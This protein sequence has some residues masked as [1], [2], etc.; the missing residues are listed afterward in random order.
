MNAKTTL[1]CF[2]VSNE[3]I[4][5]AILTVGTTVKS[6]LQPS[7]YGAERLSNSHCHTAGK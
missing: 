6:V 5:V 1:C 7:E 3:L 2:I 4:H